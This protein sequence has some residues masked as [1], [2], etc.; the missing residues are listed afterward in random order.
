M[1]II[2]ALTTF[3]SHS[4]YGLHQLKN[5]MKTEKDKRGI[6]V[7][8]ATRFSMFSTHAKS[9]TRCFGAI[10]RCLSSGA[11]KFDTQA[12]HLFVANMFNLKTETRDRLH[13]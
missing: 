12:V 5:E 11:V 8:G 6:Q 9:I 2:S 4:N 7:G 13:L 10:Q 3:F 1:T